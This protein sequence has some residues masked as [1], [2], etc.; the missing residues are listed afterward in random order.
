MAVPPGKTIAQTYSHPGGT[1]V[2]AWR[3]T[4]L[5]VANAPAP[6][7]HVLKPAGW[8]I[9]TVTRNPPAPPTRGRRG[10]RT[11]RRK[12]RRKNTRRRR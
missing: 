10:G 4:G 9:P 12:S 8:G 11:H 7:G 1:P 2:A 5:G 3:P 6:A